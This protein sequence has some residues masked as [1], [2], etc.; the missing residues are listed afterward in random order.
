MTTG[1]ILVVD[2]E[3]DLRELVVDCLKAQDYQ[4]VAAASGE[5]AVPHLDRHDL[6][7]VITDFKMPGMNG[8]ELAR[9]ALTA[10]PDRPVILMTAFADVD[11]ARQSVSIGIYDFILKPFEINDFQNTVRRA[12]NHRRLVL[13]NQEYQRNL[14]RMVEERTRE[15]QEAL[16]KLDRKVKE[17]EAR[18]RINQHLLT[19]HTPEETLSTVLEAVQGALGVERV[20]IFLPDASG[21][22][23]EPAIGAGV[24]SPEDLASW[25]TLRRLSDPWMEEARVAASRAFREGRAVYEEGPSGRGSAAVPMLRLGEVLGVVF[26][27][28][29]FSGRSLAEEDLQTLVSLTAQVAVAV[30]DARLYGEGD[31]WKTVMENLESLPPNG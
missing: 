24:Q 26:V 18:D 15:L 13:Q 14:E 5:E 27:Q 17:L 6:D 28:N 29:P 3:D 7:L 30:S 1:S 23:L 21:Q 19:V 4:M 10:D 12:L 22:K 25:E 31:Q 9:K 8:L 16:N 2:D 20:V 11:N